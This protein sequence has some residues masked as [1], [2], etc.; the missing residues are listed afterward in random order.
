MEDMAGMARVL[1]TLGHTS[2]ASIIPSC[3]SWDR[4]VQSKRQT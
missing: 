2:M 3:S 1:D 4:W